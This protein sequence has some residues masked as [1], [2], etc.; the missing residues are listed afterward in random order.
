MEKNRKKRKNQE[1]YV[2][3]YLSI[4]LFRVHEYTAGFRLKKRPFNRPLQMEQEQEEK[5]KESTGMVYY[6]FPFS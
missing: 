5:E 6:F 4:S 1:V 3:V 2:Y